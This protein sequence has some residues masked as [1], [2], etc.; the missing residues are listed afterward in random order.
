MCIIIVQ[1]VI[2][3]HC[4]QVF[5]RSRVCIYYYYYIYIITAVCTHH[6]YTK[7]VLHHFYSLSLSENTAVYSYYLRVFCPFC[8]IPL[9]V[10]AAK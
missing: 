5:V 6:R 2:H 8:L 7:R 4:D 1:N 9:C 10:F 3:T